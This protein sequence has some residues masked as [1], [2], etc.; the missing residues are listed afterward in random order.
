MPAGYLT[1]SEI[2]ESNVSPFFMLFNNDNLRMFEEL[3][4][5]KHYPLAGLMLHPAF[6]KRMCHL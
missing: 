5:V 3:E 1:V 6:P 4:A 2:V